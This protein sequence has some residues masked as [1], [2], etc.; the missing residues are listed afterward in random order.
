MISFKVNSKIVEAIA[1]KIFAVII[2]FFAVRISVSYL[3]LDQFGNWVYLLALINFAIF[4]DLGL[5]NGI[6]NELARSVEDEDLS[7]QRLIISTGVVILASLCGIIFILALLGSYLAALLG[8]LTDLTIALAGLIVLVFVLVNL[9]LSISLSVY[10]TFGYAQ[11]IVLYQLTVQLLGLCGLVVLFNFTSPSLV[12]MAI[13]YGGSLVVA[14]LLLITFFVY[15]YP[16]IIPSYKLFDFSLVKKIISLGGNFFYLQMAIFVILISD[17][18]IIGALL[19]STSVALY[20]LMFKYYGIALMVHTIFN[21]PLWPKYTAYLRSKKYLVLINKFEV[22]LGLT[23]I[24]AF[25]TM[26]STLFADYAFGVW[27]SDNKPEISFS[28]HISMAVM[29]CCLMWFSTLAYLSNGTENLRVQTV[30]VTIGALINI[31]LSYLLVSKFGLGL[32]GIAYATSISLF[33]Y[34]LAGSFE[35]VLLRRKWLADSRS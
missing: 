1:Y 5:S 10:N 29:V 35:F 9:V 15:R 8:Y 2:S 26:L 28:T 11:L 7:M 4:F 6:K 17:K 30:A 34:C 20:E 33:I 25:G 3:G 14:N 19:N 16:H 32:P 22:M 23:A 31:P 13:V 18:I 24:L 12:Y 27:L 21:T